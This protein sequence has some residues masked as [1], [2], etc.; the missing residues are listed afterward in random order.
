MKLNMRSPQRDKYLGSAP[1]DR[2]RWAAEAGS[3]LESLLAS[4]PSLIC[5]TWIWIQGWYRDAVDRPLPP[6]RVALA[7]MTAERKDLYRN[8]PTLGEPIPVVN[9][10]FSVDDGIPEDEEIAWAVHRLCLNCLCG[11]SGMQAEHLR[12]WLID[13]T[14]DDPPDT[15]NWLKVVAIVQAAFCD[16]TL[17]KECMWYTVVL[18]QNGKGDFWGVGIVEVL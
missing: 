7:T 9:L 14:R 12:Q 6:S 17:A 10:P 8:F 18:I 15:T 2:R 5:K 4:N 13:A 1:G 3:A 16:G 11:P